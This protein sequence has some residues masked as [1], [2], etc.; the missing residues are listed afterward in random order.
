ML[1]NE[2]SKRSYNKN[3][4]NE[5]DLNL[6]VVAKKRGQPYKPDCSRLRRI[7]EYRRRSAQSRSQRGYHSG[8]PSVPN[9]PE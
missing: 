6:V 5:S 1:S 3:G 9:K 2:P 4:L 8:S 7:Y